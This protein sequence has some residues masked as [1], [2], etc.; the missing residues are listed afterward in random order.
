MKKNAKLLEVKRSYP[1]YRK[2]DVQALSQD[3]KL[4]WLI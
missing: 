4:E 2:N 1:G 3:L